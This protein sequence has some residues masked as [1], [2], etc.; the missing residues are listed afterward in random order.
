[1]RKRFAHLIPKRFP[2]TEFL[3]QFDSPDCWRV[4]LSTTGDV[5]ESRSVVLFFDPT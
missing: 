5:R 1:M 2:E 3:R 4:I